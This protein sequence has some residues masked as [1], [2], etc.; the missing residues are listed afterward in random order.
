MTK[1]IANQTNS[2]ANFGMHLHIFKRMETAALVTIKRPTLKK[3][4]LK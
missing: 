4:V 1:N 3:L 2:F